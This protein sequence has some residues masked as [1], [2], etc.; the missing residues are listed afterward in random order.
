MI[1]SITNKRLLAKKW[2][3]ADICSIQVIR[4]WMFIRWFFTLHVHKTVHILKK[5]S[6]RG[7]KERERRKTWLGGH[8][9]IWTGGLLAQL[10]KL[11]TVIPGWR[12]PRTQE[13][14][15]SFVSPMH[16]REKIDLQ[17]SG[18]SWWDWGLWADIEWLWVLANVEGKQGKGVWPN[19][20]WMPRLRC[21]KQSKMKSAWRFSPYCPT[22]VTNWQW[23]E[24]GTDLP[25]EDSGGDVT[26]WTVTG[27]A[28]QIELPL[29]WF[30]EGLEDA[31]EEWVAGTEEHWK[32]QRI[33][34]AMPGVELNRGD[35]I[36]SLKMR[37]SVPISSL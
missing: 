33:K 27:L 11:D 28:N 35:C 30:Q 10:E 5:G 17:G 12:E 4:T 18:C 14:F 15:L 22:Q 26:D 13:S 1:C 36:G 34:K 37:D 6:V 31:K 25:G 8:D 16:S 23:R 2:Q 20:P 7:R 19:T 3:N 9:T 32:P 21:L 24:K 29:R